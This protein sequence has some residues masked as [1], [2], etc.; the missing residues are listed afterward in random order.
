MERNTLCALLFISLSE[1]ERS[2]MMVVVLICFFV[3]VNLRVMLE[4]SV[5]SG[6]GGFIDKG[7]SPCQKLYFVCNSVVI[8]IYSVWL[9]YTGCPDT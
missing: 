7:N 5:F 4:R 1:K 2:R 8:G 9:K 6:R 3:F